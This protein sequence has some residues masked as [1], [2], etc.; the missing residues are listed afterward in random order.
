MVRFRLYPTPAQEEILREHCAHAR[1]AWNLAL[2]QA[3]WYRSEWGPTPGYR[4]QSAQLTEARAA[5]DVAGLGVVHRATAGPARLRPS[6]EKL[7]GGHPWP[8]DVAPQGNPRRVP[9]VAVRP[10][11]VRRLNRHW[12][13]VFVPRLGRVRFRWTRAPGGVKSYRVTQ[14]RAGRW[15]LAFAQVPMPLD[16]Q[17]TGTAVGIDR[18]VT[19]ALATS[20]GNFLHAPVLTTTERAG[21]ARLQRQFARQQKG[22]ARRARTR[23][24]IAR[25]RAHEADRVKDWVEK[26]TTT[27]VLS[28]DL[29][30]IENLAVRQMTRSAPGYPRQSG[31]QRS[32]QGWSQ[33][34]DPGPA[35]GSVRT[36]PQRKSRPR[37]SGRHRD[38]SGVHQSTLLGL[39]ACGGGES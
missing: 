39:W 11:H 8:P 12:G 29:I 13:D 36:A 3:N 26:T 6:H 31:A 28:H 18:G 23:R 19:N 17:P 20:D 1:F 9:F 4:A 14:D 25:R 33:P 5:S 35:V 30:A 27:L 24:R 10:D 15:H 16:R 7:L 22:S 21:H 34:G 32:S 2:E 38:P 37:R